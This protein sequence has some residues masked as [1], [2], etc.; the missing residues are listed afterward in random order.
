MPSL[1]TT[2]VRIYE[3]SNI[4]HQY[5]HS[6]YCNTD[7]ESSLF[8]CNDE[9]YDLMVRELKELEKQYPEFRLEDSPTI[10]L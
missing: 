9:T 10:F 7:S 3:L 2:Q 1:S 8:G 4:I 5:N 6:Y